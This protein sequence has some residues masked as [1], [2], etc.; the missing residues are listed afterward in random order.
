LLTPNFNRHVTRG[1][2][3]RYRLPMRKPEC[4]LCHAPAINA[5]KLR[6]CAQCGWQKKQTET[7]LRLNLKIVPIAFGVMMLILGI[8]FFR[9]GAGA[10]NPELIAFF[11]TFPL[12]ALGI[13]YAITRRNLN[14]LL[15][16]APPLATPSGASAAPAVNPTLALSPQYEAILKTSA[17][18]SLRM[19]RRGTFNLTLTLVVLFVFAGIIVLQLYRSWAVARSFA[20]FQLRE[21]GLAG[22]ALL[23][24]LM[25]VSQWRAMDRER[26]LLT[27]GEVVPAKIVQKIGSRS[28][29]AIKYE[30]ED[31]A[32]QKHSNTGTDYTQKLEEGMTVPVFYD[33]DNPNR[34]VPACG[35]F[36]EVVLKEEGKSV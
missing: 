21:W 17:P 25:L 34:Q 33:R 28:A 16:Q 13:S 26:G 24:L 35:T 23:L 11:L 2:V 10:Q 15:A 31:F 1:E 22:F 6:Y 29:S 9:T 8:L 3:L 7:Q 5:G 32:G 27:N 4:P 14:I 12:I 18:R 19:S 20:G 30:F 36:H